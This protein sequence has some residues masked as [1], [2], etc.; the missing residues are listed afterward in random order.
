MN[1][2]PVIIVAPRLSSENEMGAQ[3]LHRLPP[4]CKVTKKDAY[5]LPNMDS[6]L[7][8]LRG[9]KY[10]SKI[11]LKAAYHQI[12]MARES[13]KYT[14]FAVPGSGLC[15]FTRMPFGLTKAPMTF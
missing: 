15:Q 13:K 5:P 7:D 14:A 2:L 8:K 3:N 9:T 11:D 12:P 6:I 4:L 10:L 1:I